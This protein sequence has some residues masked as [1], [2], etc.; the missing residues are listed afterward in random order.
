MSLGL[1]LTRSECH[2]SAGPLR[3]D[4]KLFLFVASSQLWMVAIASASD[5]HDD[6]YCSV[7]LPLKL[8]MAWVSSRRLSAVMSS[9]IGVVAI[10]AC[11]G[12][13]IGGCEKN[14]RF[15]GWGDTGLLTTCV[16]EEKDEMLESG[17]C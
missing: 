12:S 1:D 6:I 13:G 2:F 17:F 5:S 8:G 7:A 4:A 3:R 10:V 9:A 14:G 16:S 15:C 11:V